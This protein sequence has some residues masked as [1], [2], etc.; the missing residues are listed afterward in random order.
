MNFDWL[1]NSSLTARVLTLSTA[2]VVAGLVTYNALNSPNYEN[3]TAFVDPGRQTVAY[4]SGS[5]RGYD[6]NKSFSAADIDRVDR[7]YARQNALRAQGEQEPQNIRYVSEEY[8]GT[9]GAG[10]SYQVDNGRFG[11]NTGSGDGEDSL[12]SLINNAPGFGNLS[13]LVNNAAGGAVGQGGA[14]AG[15]A[16]DAGGKGD[17]SFQ[18]ASMAVGGNAPGS[19][20]FGNG[21]GGNNQGINNSWDGAGGSKSD[22]QNATDALAQANKMMQD[23]KEGNHLSGKGLQTNPKARFASEALKGSLTGGGVGSMGKGKLDLEKERLLAM[24][25]ANKKQTASNAIAQVYMGDDGESLPQLEENTYIPESTGD[26]PQ[27]TEEQFQADVESAGEGL[28]QLQE[29]LRNREK[30]GWDLKATAWVLFGITVA[31]CVAIWFLKKI[32]LWGMAAALA[33]LAT[34][35]GLMFKLGQEIYNFSKNWSFEGVAWLAT[36]LLVAGVGGLAASFFVG[37]KAAL[38]AAKAATGSAAASAIGGVVGTAAGTVVGKGADF[39][40]K[41]AKDHKKASDAVKGEEDSQS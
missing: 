9:N 15:G 34:G 41:A 2:V 25:L 32:P 35:L 30:D 1:K 23:L 31:L 4:T 17:T 22:V 10:E 11:L 8:G 7:E 6:G 19:K 20:G 27:M 37:A 14:G 40:T 29:N 16:G 13:D 3:G 5:D 39:A 18:R 26:N 21:I 36:G 28:N 24:R 38:A 33:L 12:A